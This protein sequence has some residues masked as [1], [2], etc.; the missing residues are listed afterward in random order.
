MSSIIDSIR[1]EFLRYKR[2]A[3]SAID[4]LDESD[5]VAPGPNSIA[6]I[7]RH[8]SGNLR[9]R[10]TDFLTSDGEKPW[11]Q[12]ETEFEERQVSKMELMQRWEEGWTVLIAT[13]E[14]M[15][16]DDLAATITIR[17]TPMPAHQ[18][19]A[20]SLAHISYHVGQIVYAAREIRGDAWQFLSIPPGGTEAYNRNPDRETGDTHAAGLGLRATE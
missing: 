12:R 2:L 6:T 17:R 19:L 5:V 13:L 4:Q 14:A 9:S 11:R 8:I 16:D 18:A 10:F 15:S 20:R 7:C 3:E 1:S